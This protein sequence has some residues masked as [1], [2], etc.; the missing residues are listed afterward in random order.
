MHGAGAATEG[1]ILTHR[2]R[3]MRLEQ[4]FE[5]ANPT[6]RDTLLPT[7]PHLLFKWCQILMTEHSNI[8]LQT[9]IYT[10]YHIC[11]AS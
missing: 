10:D 3:A 2:Q 1:Y 6:P 4:A 9:Y 11:P 7:R 8:S 5:T